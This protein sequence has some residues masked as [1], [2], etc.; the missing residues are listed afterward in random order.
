MNWEQRT[1][2]QV[3]IVLNYEVVGQVCV[4]TQLNG[5]TEETKRQQYGPIPKII[6]GLEWES[7]FSFIQN[8]IGWRYIC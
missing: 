6:Q 1:D 3:F 2:G 8:V 7:L 4:I 5:Q